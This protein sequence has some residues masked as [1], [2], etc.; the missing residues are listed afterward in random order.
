M[1]LN[2]ARQRISQKESYTPE[3]A[4]QI[5]RQGLR[6]VYMIHDELLTYLQTKSS[7]G[8]SKL[9]YACSGK[10]PTHLFV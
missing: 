4:F 3:E 5:A 10:I 2:D 8:N 7:V 1:A 9:L 6:E